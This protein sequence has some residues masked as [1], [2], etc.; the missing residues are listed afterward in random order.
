[1]KL[2]KRRHF[3][4][5]EEDER[6]FVET[7]F[8]NDLSHALAKAVDAHGGTRAAFA[9]SI[10]MAPQYLSEVLS[11]EQ[12]ITARTIARI[13]YG[14]GR[15]PSVGFKPLAGLDG[16]RTAVASA[17]EERPVPVRRGSRSRG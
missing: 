17:E 14:L 2:T 16:A 7:T 12:N 3:I 1:M 9:E 15:F 10:G 6:R 11:G 13:A 5:T 4:Q 8:I